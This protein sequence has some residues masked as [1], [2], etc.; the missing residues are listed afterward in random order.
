MSIISLQTKLKKERIKLRVRV[1]VV[2]SS[3]GRVVVV[4]VVVVVGSS[5]GRVVVVVVVGSSRGR[6]RISIKK[7]LLF[8]PSSDSIP[9]LFQNSLSYLIEKNIFSISRFCGKIFK[10]S[11]GLNAMLSTK[12]APKFLTN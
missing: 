10:D 4:V 11:I 7:R 12:S 9:P 1:V 5:R 8:T 2:G 6:V 3:R